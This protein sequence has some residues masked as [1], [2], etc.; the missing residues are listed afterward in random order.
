MLLKFSN[1]SNPPV[2][3][4]IVNP[5]LQSKVVKTPSLTHFDAKNHVLGAKTPWFSNFSIELTNFDH[6][7][8][9]SIE[10]WAILMQLRSSCQILSFDQNSFVFDLPDRIDQFRPQIQNQWRLFQFRSPL[11][12][13]YPLPL[14]LIPPPRSF[15]H[16]SPLFLQKNFNPRCQLVHFL[17]VNPNLQSKVVKTKFFTHFDAKNRVLGAKTPLFLTFPTELTNFDL[18]FG[19]SVK[20]WATLILVSNF[21][22]WVENFLSVDLGK[23]GKWTCSCHFRNWS[24]TTVVRP[25]KILVWVSSIEWH[26]FR[27]V[28]LKKFVRGP[29]PVSTDNP[30]FWHRQST[31]H[32]MVIK[33]WGRTPMLGALFQK[34][35]IWVSIFR[36]IPRHL[37][38]FRPKNRNSTRG[39]KLSNFRSWFRICGQNRSNQLFWPILTPKTMFLRPKLL[40]F[41]TFRSNWPISTS[42]S[43]SASKIEQLWCN[44]DP[45]VKFWFLAKNSFV[46]DL[47]NQIDQFRPQ[48]CTQHQNLSNFDPRD[49]F[50]FLAKSPLFL[51]FPIELANFD[52]RFGIS[53]DNFNFVAPSH[54]FTPPPPLVNTPLPGYFGTIFLCF[55]RNFSTRVVN[56][57]N[58]WWWIRICSQKW[59]K[60]N[61]WPILTPKTEFLGPKLLCFW[62]SRPNWPIS[63][64]DS[65]SASKIEQLWSSCQ[66][67]IFGSKIF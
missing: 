25:S 58:F 56:L 67:S 12:P 8:G 16:N 60:Q 45:R 28:I 63:T 5:N 32:M 61:F 55:W 34:L 29:P 13:F 17:M 36:K 20:N 23:S 51:T 40:G 11:P 14:S 6:R 2:Q 62:P 49:K 53:E 7:F 27:G 41:Q 57:F 24:R 44:F 9:I 30:N 26:H 15:W 33:M 37:E 10:N 18:R 43:E 50:R 3:F 22:F 35:Q 52:L 19:I 66:I 65:E 47:S 31:Q 59:S 4:L 46:F 39:S 21:D 38:K 64:S 42:D 1:P 54:L 48:F